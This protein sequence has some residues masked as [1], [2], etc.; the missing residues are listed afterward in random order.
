[1]CFNFLHKFCVLRGP[2]KQVLD[3]GAENFSEVE[4]VQCL[5]AAAGIAILGRHSDRRVPSLAGSSREVQMP[6]AGGGGRA[7]K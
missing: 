5:A 7:R 2:C 3:R 4:E 1:M 6:L